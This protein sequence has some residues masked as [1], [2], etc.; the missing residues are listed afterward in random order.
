KDTETQVTV[1]K[2]TGTQVTATQNTEIKDPI[3]TQDERLLSVDFAAL[4]GHIR[5]V[6]LILTFYTQHSRSTPKQSRNMLFRAVHF[7]SFDALKLLL[8]HKTYTNEEISDALYLATQKRDA[9][10]MEVLL[11]LKV[12]VTQMTL[13]MNLY[14]LLCLVSTQP[15][16][17]TGITDLM[18]NQSRLA[19]CFKVLIKYSHD[20][21]SRVPDRTYPLYSLI[22]AIFSKIF[23]EDSDNSE[24][25]RSTVEDGLQCLENLLNAGADPNFN[26]TAAAT[27]SNEETLIISG[28]LAFPSALVCVVYKI[29]DQVINNTVDNALRCPG[30]DSTRVQIDQF[31][32]EVFEVLL[33]HGAKLHIPDRDPHMESLTDPLGFILMTLLMCDKANPANGCSI[34]CHFIKPLID[35][36]ELVLVNGGNLE[37][38]TNPQCAASIDISTLS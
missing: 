24:D 1:S 29:Y 25:L 2:D 28:R 8:K 5:L 31:V 19:E 4:F 9:K 21:N 13:N 23:N 32:V 17:N 30:N 22:W 16:I 14:H 36:L 11:S 15:E 34:N 35:L 3:E 10:C 26:E 6:E 38:M 33:Q 7:G 18:N 27:Y 12:P 37:K 20:V